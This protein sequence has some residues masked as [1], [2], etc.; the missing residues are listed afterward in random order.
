[1]TDAA[2]GTCAA[3][4]EA[5]AREPSVALEF[6]GRLR[7]ARSAA[8]ADAEGYLAVVQ[9]V[10]ELGNFLACKSDRALGQLGGVLG[11][12]VKKASPEQH[13][14]FGSLLDALREGRND[15]VHVG[16]RARR[17]ARQAVDVAIALE[18]ALM[19]MA[20]EPKV[21][22]YMVKDV[23]RAEGWHTVAMARRSMMAHQFSA[24]P[25]YLDGVWRVLRDRDVAA[26]WRGRGSKERDK[27]VDEAFKGGDLRPALVV[28]RCDSLVVAARKF[29]DD[30]GGAMLAVVCDEDHQ[31]VGIVTPFDLL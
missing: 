30:P 1:M 14:E 18:E 23:T 11:H 8:L 20:G 24:L 7:T 19:E 10:E 31:L 26:F 16:A 25:V 6:A 15:A 5:M 21:E 4:L 9:A 3:R 29:K 27:R 13:A 2:G 28:G 12:L 17:M 22:H